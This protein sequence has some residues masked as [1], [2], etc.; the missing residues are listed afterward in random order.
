MSTTT[1][2]KPK[3]VRKRW[4][5]AKPPT[6]KRLAALRRRAR[7]PIDTS[8]SP[9]ITQEDLASGR[10]RIV[11]RGPAGRK[12]SLTLRLDEDLLEWFKSQGE[13]YQTRINDALRAYRA[14]AESDT[15]MEAALEKIEALAAMLRQRVK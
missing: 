14:Q 8:D 1:S 15:G 12:R 7:G 10:A 9:P 3:P 4:T 13:G 5:D 6:A 2:R 11:R